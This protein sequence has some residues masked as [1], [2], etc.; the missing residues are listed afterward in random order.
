MA[1]KTKSL[2]ENQEK[3]CKITNNSGK[4]IV[5]AL[6]INDDETTGQDAVISANQ[7]VEIL[8]TSGGNTV[9]KNGGS[10]TVTLDH[11]Y[12]SGAD[13]TGYVPD[14]HLI[15]SDCN[16][17][18]PLADLSVVQQGTNGSAS[19][20]SQTV[21]VTNEAAMTHAFDFY[22]T[23]TGY[24]SSQLAKDYM[25]ALQQT[26]DAVLAAA[27][28][29]TDSAKAVSDAIEIRMNS[30]FEGTQ[31][32]KDVT[33]ADI[34]AIDNYYNNFPFVW[35]QYR[36]SLT[37]YLYGT[38]GTSASF[39]GT[40]SLN[41]SGAVDITK[42]NGG[43]TCAFAPAVNPSETSKTD[44]D[45]TQSVNL[46]YS[47]G[48]FLDDPQSAS[49]K[50]GLKGSFLLERLFTN[51]P[52]DNNII[53]VLSGMVN[54]ITCIGFDTPQ[55]T[56]NSLQ[57][58]NKTALAGSSAQKY[59][60]AL[61]HPKNQM[62]LMASI[63]TLV[64]A[65]LLVPATAGAI[66]GVYRIALYRAQKAKQDAID[67]QIIERSK[68]YMDNAIDVKVGKWCGP[69]KDW[70]VEKNLNNI[71]G[72]NKVLQNDA[73]SI[74]LLRAFN[75]QW[76]CLQKYLEYSVVFNS[77]QSVQL[78]ENFVSIHSAIEVLHEC[79]PVELETELPGCYQAFSDAQKCIQDLGTVVA[80]ELSA[81]AQQTV[82]N[83]IAESSMIFANIENSTKKDLEEE[84]EINPEIREEIK[85]FE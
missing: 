56:D 1:V 40:L 84:S 78:Q 41:K 53:S 14:Y 30:F 72:Y 13:E 10:D 4:D 43:Y 29:G 76:K 22:Q 5:V 68:N 46:T 77:S 6:I 58:G 12:K 18:Y 26:D 11:N 49:P 81:E 45:T 28:G 35:A 17:L 60:D 25:S 34:V 39:A 3:L 2:A 8:K 85:P 75:L 64:G 20:T 42:S 38:D 37:Y 79:T 19:Y 23:I 51:D 57:E 61:I 83:D 80:K 50:I 63:L 82:N 55:P 48:L 33:L 47:D 67:K 15:V 65:I 44:V 32:Y 74:K 59:W 16:W 69:R 54:G 66:Y 24:P 62:D 9:I 52:D 27:D 21:D 73:K 31:E 71:E 7:Q 70:F 36:D